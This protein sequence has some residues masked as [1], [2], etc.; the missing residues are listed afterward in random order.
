MLNV[1][2][3]ENRWRRYK[4]KSYIPYVGAFLVLVV[5]AIVFMLFTTSKTDK[6]VKA[7]NIKENKSQRKIV[8]EK[9]IVASKSKVKEYKITQK[10]HKKK[11]IIKTNKTQKVVLSPSLNFISDI[12]FSPNYQTNKKQEIKK[13]PQ[14]VVKTNEIKVVEKKLETKQK[15]VVAK[16]IKK[17]LISASKVN[18]TNIIK[19]ETTKKDI[20]DVLKRFQKSNNPALSLF[21]AKKYYE[22]GEYRQS[23]NYALVT[24]GINDNIESSWIIFAKSL[25]KLNRKDEAIKTLK[26]Y[27]NHTDSSQARILLEDI[28][29]GKFR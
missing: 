28:I 27:I 5:F 11:E 29:S 16:E 1:I 17:P 12:K 7:E 24:N 14:T 22:L 9:P 18:R 19:R 3:L 25:V 10:L 4:I 20:N 6:I 26:R 8:L 21:I 13:P 2:E 23:Y 15:I